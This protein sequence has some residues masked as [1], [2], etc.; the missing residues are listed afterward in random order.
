MWVGSFRPVGSQG[1]GLGR[2]DLIGDNLKYHPLP[3][4][5][6]VILGES[7]G[8]STG[9]VFSK[10]HDKNPAVVVILLLGYVCC[11]FCCPFGQVQAAVLDVPVSR[12]NVL[13]ECLEDVAALQITAVVV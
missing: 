12:H 8:S 5:G 1:K 11:N 7:L 6:D 2:K 9:V 3:Y 13:L 4:Q 10:L